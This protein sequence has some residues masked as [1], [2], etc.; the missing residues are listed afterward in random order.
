MFIASYP[1]SCRRGAWVSCCC[2]LF[3]ESKVATLQTIDK[4]KLEY[5]QALGKMYMFICKPLTANVSIIVL[6][7]LQ[8]NLLHFLSPCFNVQTSRSSTRC[9]RSVSLKRWGDPYIASD[10]GRRG[11]PYFKRY[12]DG[13]PHFTGV[14]ISRLHRHV[15]THHYYASI[16]RLTSFPGPTQLFV[17]W[18]WKSGRGPGIFCHVSDT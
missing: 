7:P 10:M 14:P 18:I 1:G 9:L 3:S 5:Q 8:K 15:F 12:G 17:A 6:S 4:G 11:S 16:P 13:G 2:T